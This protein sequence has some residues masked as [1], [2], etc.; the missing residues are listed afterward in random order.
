MYGRSE[1]T[2]AT[3]VTVPCA[4]RTS[5]YPEGHFVSI[6]AFNLEICDV[7]M[8]SLA[9]LETDDGKRFWFKKRSNE[10]AE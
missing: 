9:L 8:A 4:K 10:N 7:C 5:R 2:N 1:I 6:E 3:I